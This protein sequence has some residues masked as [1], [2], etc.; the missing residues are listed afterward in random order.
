MA[1][2]NGTMNCAMDTMRLFSGEGDEARRESA[3]ASVT[4]RHAGNVS[5]FDR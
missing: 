2:F 5:R 3:Q 1:Q 4:R